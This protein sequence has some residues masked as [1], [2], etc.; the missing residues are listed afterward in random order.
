MIMILHLLPAAADSKLVL[1]IRPI[2]DVFVRP[3]GGSIMFTCEVSPREEQHTTTSDMLEGSNSTDNSSYDANYLMTISDIA[4]TSHVTS[5]LEVITG[6]HLKVV[7]DF[8]SSQSIA[9]SSTNANDS[10]RVNVTNTEQ[11]KE[12]KGLLGAVTGFLRKITK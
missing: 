10:I 3:L 5:H 4:E 2:G 8:I 11:P 6:S 12:N 1:K 9:P 7:T